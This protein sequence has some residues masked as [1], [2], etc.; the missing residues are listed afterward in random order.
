MLWVLLLATTG[1]LA[2]E[3][4]RT[5]IKFVDYF[6]ENASRVTWD[7]Q[8]DSIMKIALLPDY[9]RTALNRQTTHCYFRLVADAGAHVK[10]L[11]TKSVGGYYNGKEV[12]LS[13][14]WS[15]EYDNPLYISYDQKEWT[16]VK[17]AKVANGVDLL[18]ELDMAHESVYIADLPPYTLTDLEHFKAR[19]KTSESV[20]IL[21][22]GK[23]EENRPIEV[24][25][26]GNPDAANVF[27]IRARAHPWESGGNWVVEGL[28][29]EFIAKADTWEKSFCVF[30][31][32]MANKDGVARGM[33]RF[34]VSGMDL[35]RNWGAAPDARLCPE[36]YAL[37]TFIKGLVKKGIKPRLAIDLHNDSYGGLMLGQVGE[38]DN[39]F[40]ERIKSFEGLMHRFTSFSEKLKFTS[41]TREHP[42]SAEKFQFNDGLRRR[43]GIDAVVYELNA[44]WIGSL[45]K[46]PS[47]SDFKK[48]G[49]DLN[50]VFYEYSRLLTS[51]R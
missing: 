26:L 4:P 12:P 10:F 35:N 8:G 40:M 20:K 32:P 18:V 28:V 7:I 13:K 51:R 34:T 31:V 6:F 1:L 24:I 33:T 50:T 5:N 11:L 46:I 39:D 37:E 2:Q 22:I 9:E 41:V 47:V 45:G 14:N 49:H 19:I 15:V 17:T 42:E 25:Q 43:F 29:S 38:Q 44:H 21:N 16:P 27:I 36:N 48:V 3:N 23:T 30:I